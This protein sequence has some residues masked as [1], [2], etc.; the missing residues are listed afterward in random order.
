MWPSMRALPVSFVHG[1]DHGLDGST[2]SGV[3]S[4]SRG[5]V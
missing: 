1:K 5:D 3:P 4:L 2:L